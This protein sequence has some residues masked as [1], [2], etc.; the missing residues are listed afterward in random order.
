[1]SRTLNTRPNRARPEE[2]VEDHDHR[3]GECD[4][5]TLEFYLKYTEGTRWR[6]A[7]DTRCTWRVDWN[8]R[9]DTRCSC[10]LCRDPWWAD[11]KRKKQAGPMP[12]MEDY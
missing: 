6:R 7:L 3:N 5:P 9:H 10:D 2:Y 1:M 4:L 12:K 11:F 8:K